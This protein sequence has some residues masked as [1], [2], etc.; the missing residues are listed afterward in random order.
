MPDKDRGNL[1]ARLV[2]G[3][4]GRSDDKTE[5]EYTK[6]AAELAGSV[7][8]TIEKATDLGLTVVED[9]GLTL[10]EAMSPSKPSSRSGA[11][12]AAASLLSRTRATA[13]AVTGQVANK[14]TGLLVNGGFEIL[15]TIHRAVRTTGRPG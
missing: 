7:G 10:L 15:H 3:A 9:I 13:P 1:R 12:G 14:L 6:L 4:P 5:A 2:S 8:K 11:M